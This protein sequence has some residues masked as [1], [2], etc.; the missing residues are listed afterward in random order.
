MAA[1]K[2]AVVERATELEAQRVFVLDEMWSFQDDQEAADEAEDLVRRGRHFRLGTFFMTQRPMDALDSSLGK[3]VQSQCASQWFGMQ[4]PSEISD[5]SSRLRWT[6]EQIGVIERFGPGD[7]MLVAGL[8]RVAFRVDYSP[9]EFA[10]AHTDSTKGDYDGRAEHPDLDVELA[11]WTVAGRSAER[12][13]YATL[14]RTSSRLL[15][16][17]RQDLIDSDNSDDEDDPDD[18]EEEEERRRLEEED[19]DEAA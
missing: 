10:M 1:F 7:A 19:D 11:A 14:D 18:D 2:R 9:D 15:D 17:Y 3:T 16:E 4:N 6:P 12:D 8:N 5:V 13:P